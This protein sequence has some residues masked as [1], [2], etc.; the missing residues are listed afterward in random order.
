MLLI[1]KSLLGLRRVVD[2]SPRELQES[3]SV[4]L[5]HAVTYSEL[6]YLLF[7]TKVEGLWRMVLVATAPQTKAVPREPGVESCAIYVVTASWIHTHHQHYH[8]L[9]PTQ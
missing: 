3:V 8:L 7:A 1:E 2:V 5:G 4:C 6:Q 9:A